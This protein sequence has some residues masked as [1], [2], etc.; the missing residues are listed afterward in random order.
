M[1]RWGFHVSNHTAHHANVGA[2]PTAE[3]LAEITRARDDL[4][5]ELGDREALRWFAYPYGKPSDI[6]EEVRSSL[7]GLGITHCASAFGGMNPPDFDPLNILRQGIDH[8]FTA[9]RLRAAIEGWRWRS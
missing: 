7:A 1:D 8:K 4:R 9:L 6:T 3:A 2:L 5:R